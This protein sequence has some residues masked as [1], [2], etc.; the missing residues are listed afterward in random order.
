MAAWSKSDRQASSD[1][2]ASDP[3][4]KN[5]DLR[6]NRCHTRNIPSQE[7]LQTRTNPYVSSTITDYL[8]SVC[9]FY[10]SP[11]MGHLPHA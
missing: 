2:P 1:D 10:F 6:P 4:K 5:T 3:D 9:Y 8:I 7:K 11:A